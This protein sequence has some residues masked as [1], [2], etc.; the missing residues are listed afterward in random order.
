MPYR[1][2]GTLKLPSGVV[3]AGVDIKFK[4][5]KT[6]SPLI[7]QAEIVIRTDAAGK[8]DVTLEFNT[9]LCEVTFS[10]NRPFNAGQFTV[11]SDTVVG[12]DLPTLLN[13]GGWQPATPE[14]IIQIQTW[15]AEANASAAAA[16]TSAKAAKVS[17][18]NSKASETSASSSASSALSSKNASKTSE[19]NAATSA[20][21]AS[22]SA[23]QAS[24]SANRA[25][26]SETNAANSASAAAQ[27]Q[28]LAKTSET[29]AVAAADRAE[30]AAQ[31]VVGA[32]V[33][34]GPY[35]P[36]TGTLPS[37]VTLGGQKR[38][39]IWKVTGTGLVGGIDLGSG[40]SLIYTSRDD[41]Y[42]KIDNTESVSKVNNKT[43]VVVL[44]ATDVDAVPIDKCRSASLE[45][46]GQYL[47]SGPID[48]D[49]LGAGFNG[50]VSI[51]TA[52]NAPPLAATGSGFVHLEVQK[53]YV[54]DIVQ[55]TLP[56]RG[57]K[58]IAFRTKKG[59]V[60]EPW[61]VSYT[62]ANK[63]TATEVGADPS[64]TASS[65]ITTHEAKANAHA[66]AG[67]NG[68]QAALDTKQGAGTV[69][70]GGSTAN[71]N[72]DTIGNFNT[73]GLSA[74]F[75]SFQYD[76]GNGAGASSPSATSYAKYGVALA[77]S[78]GQFKLQMIIGADGGIA[79]RG[80]NN[81]TL[82][83]FG[84]VHYRDTRNTTVDGNGFIKK[85]SPIVR[86]GQ[87]EETDGFTRCGQGCCNEEA[88][89]VS[90][91]H[92]GNGVYRIFGSLGFAKD[93]WYIETPSDAN[94]NKL[95]HVEYTSLNNTIEVRTF[96]PN[97]S[98]GRCESGEP[99]DIPSGR[100]IDVRL[101]MPKK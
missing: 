76:D 67:V 64:G 70:Q 38:S 20:S 98:N 2:T 74:T 35:D 13:S 77:L 81:G 48:F 19:T 6:F 66:I 22:A 53:T 42:Y 43:G 32:L 58:A 99:A 26:T 3:A 82:S 79:T 31:T 95:R 51:S 18:T 37:P 61:I 34:G 87:L 29:T 59:D 7:E 86:V 83:T 88:N 93:G 40:D 80:A 45:N 54:G 41:S 50:L 97:Y 39:T 46:Y 21:Q 10:T 5:L 55:T 72:W 92:S 8:Y 44:T 75:E 71:K 33:D 78:G 27:S 73:Q 30:Q 94:G 17:E 96:I 60:W 1:I 101:E 14:W 100:W 4:A 62:T 85:A 69:K 84:W 36:T 24:T 25:S 89:G 28:T 49:G 57:A 47:S 15:L 56:F 11:A 91:E 63:P 16:D 23:S 68:L 9:Y 90:V 52:L 12:K 65:A